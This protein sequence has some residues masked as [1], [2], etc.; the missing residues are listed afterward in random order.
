MSKLS[1]YSKFD[2]LDDDDDNDSQSGSED[3]QKRIETMKSQS[4]SQS[5][6]SSVP[7]QKPEQQP[8]APTGGGGGGRIVHD[9]EYYNKQN[10]SASTMNN[11]R[12]YFEFNGQRIYDFEQTLDD[13][14]L[15]VRPPPHIQRGHQIRCEITA[16]HLKLGLKGHDTWFLNEDTFDTVDVSESTWSLEDNN[17][18]DDDSNN[19][20]KGGKVIAIYLIKAHRGRLWE[21]VLKGN[22]AA[23]ATSPATAAA[24][25]TPTIDPVQKE[26]IKKSL[27]LQRFQEENPGFDFSG[28]EINGSAPDARE[29]MGGV[30]YQ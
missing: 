7:A 6:S 24:T 10:G 25:T 9:T 26:E 27:L 19:N 5:Q 4:S 17:D 21:A 11:Q 16:T 14:T 1:E 13:M 29:F 2:H 18:D 3:A 12:Y 28:A 22:P 20:K 15:F 8:H 30:K 23:T